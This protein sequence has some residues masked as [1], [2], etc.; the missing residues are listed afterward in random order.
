MY[1]RD[2]NGEPL[3]AVSYF[4]HE[5]EMTR[6]ERIIKRLARTTVIETI[7]FI[8]YLLINLRR[9]IL[10]LTKEEST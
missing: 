4:A 10:I 6:L 8:I 5:M 3:A 7:L 2:K 9:Q 1:I